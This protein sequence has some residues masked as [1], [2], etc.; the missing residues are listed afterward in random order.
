MILNTYYGFLLL[1]LFSEILPS[2]P[3]DVFVEA[4]SDKSVN[5]SWSPPYNNAKSVTDYIVN[6]TM[7][8]S[9]DPSSVNIYLSGDSNSSQ[10]VITP[11]SVQVKVILFWYLLSF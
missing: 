6:V 9:F 2:A 7:L 10:S 1:F 4:K 3:V 8:Q 11:H 5:V